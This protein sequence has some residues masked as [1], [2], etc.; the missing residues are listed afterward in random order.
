MEVKRDPNQH[1]RFVFPHEVSKI[2][3]HI[4]TMPVYTGSGTKFA[5]AIHGTLSVIHLCEIRDLYFAFESGPVVEAGGDFCVPIN[6]SSIFKDPPDAYT[7]I[8]SVVIMY[9]HPAR[10]FSI[11]VDVDM[12]ILE[13]AVY[14]NINLQYNPKLFG[15]YIGYPEMLTAKIPPFKAGAGFAFQAGKDDSFIAAK[16]MLGWQYNVNLGIVYLKGYVEGGASGEYHFAG[17][18]KGTFLLEIY[19]RGG[20]KGGVN[21]LGKKFDII[22]F[23]LNAEGALYKKSS[24][25]WNLKAACEVGYSLDLFLFSAHGSVHANF[26]TTF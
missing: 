23:Y 21:A 22:S 14:G 7:K 24:G 3:D 5:A 8:G 16:M 12:K 19:L 15:I 10:H 25:P 11:N 17:V 6:P 2:K 26:N 1:N 9:N 4:K 13:I 18:D 20:I